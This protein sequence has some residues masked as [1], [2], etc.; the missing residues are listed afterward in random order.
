[1]TW[2]WKALEARKTLKG[3]TAGTINYKELPENILTYLSTQLARVHSDGKIAI[4]LSN[5]QRLSLGSNG[6]VLQPQVSRGIMN[7]FWGSSEMVEKAM[8]EF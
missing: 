6:S 3:K 8:I 7:E 2:T 4:Q 5:L 1:V